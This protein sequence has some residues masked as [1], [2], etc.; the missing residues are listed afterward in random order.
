MTDSRP[1]YLPRTT[2]RC[3]S[4]SIDATPQNLTIPIECR[5]RKFSPAR[6]SAANTGRRLNGFGESGE[7]TL[8]VMRLNPDP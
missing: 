3:R 1:L 5:F 7:Y 6:L 8:F 2:F 4:Y